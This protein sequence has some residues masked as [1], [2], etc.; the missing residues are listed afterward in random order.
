MMMSMSSAQ[1]VIDHVV[2]VC[3]TVSCVPILVEAFE[4]RALV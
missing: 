2:V 4:S 3:L 1:S